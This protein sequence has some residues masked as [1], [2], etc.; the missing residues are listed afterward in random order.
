MLVRQGTPEDDFASVI[1]SPLQPV[2]VSGRDATKDCYSTGDNDITKYSR[3][4]TGEVL[5]VCCLMLQ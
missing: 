3:N 2:I 4:L 5:P 1:Q